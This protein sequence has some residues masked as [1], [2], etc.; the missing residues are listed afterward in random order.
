MLH[1]KI[2]EAVLLEQHLSFLSSALE[3]KKYTK[4]RGQ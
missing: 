3:E 1:M 2:D 4:K